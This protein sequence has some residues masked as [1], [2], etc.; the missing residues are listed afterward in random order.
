MTE[1]AGILAKGSY[2][3]IGI[4]KGLAEGLA[5]GRE[6]GLAIGARQ[7]LLT[8]IEVALE[9]RFATN[10]LA[11]LPEIRKIE[12]ITVLQSIL[13]AIKQADTPER[14]RRFWSES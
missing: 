12:D 3:R 13:G 4:E 9:L 1:G 6:E 11:L 8:G 7:S 10:G 5:K 14:L 2:K